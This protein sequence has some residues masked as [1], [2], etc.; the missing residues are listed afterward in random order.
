MPEDF[1][2][3]TWLVGM[4]RS[5]FELSP[6]SRLSEAVGKHGDRPL[7]RIECPIIGNSGGTTE[8]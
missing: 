2:E 3:S 4:C 1:Q 5:R 6:W 8:L 7:Q